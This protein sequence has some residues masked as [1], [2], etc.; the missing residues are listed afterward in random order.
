MLYVDMTCLKQLFW[1]FENT[2][3]NIM[4]IYYY[5]LIIFFVVVADIKKCRP[6]PFSAENQKGIIAVIQNH[7]VE[8]QAVQTLYSD[9]AILVLNGALLYSGDIYNAFLALN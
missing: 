8:N 2:W 4:N 9:S 3:H 5:Y 6:S 1:Q 7:S